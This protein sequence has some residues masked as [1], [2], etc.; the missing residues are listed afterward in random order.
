MG[1]GGREVSADRIASPHRTGLRKP[2]INCND[3]IEAWNLIWARLIDSAPT[4]KAD[5]ESTDD[6]EFRPRGWNPE[7]R[8]RGGGGGFRK[9]KEVG[10]LFKNC[11]N[12]GG[13]GLVF[14]G[15][16]FFFFFLPACERRRCAMRVGVGSVGR[17]RSIDFNS[18]ECIA[19]KKKSRLR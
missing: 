8:R 7:T 10:G 17:E 4:P 5:D 1:E 16:N 9:R 6:D 13:V 2:I 12:K 3:S 14:F 11:Q 18:I 15:G 19:R